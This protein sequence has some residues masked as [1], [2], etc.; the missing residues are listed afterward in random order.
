M[1][2]VILNTDGNGLWS[3]VRRAV[4]VVNI[5]LGTGRVRRWEAVDCIFGELRVYFDC[6]TWNTDRD[7]LIYTDERFLRELQAFLKV[8]GLPG[9]DVYYSEQGMQGDDYVSLDAGTEFY[10]AWMKKFGI[11][12]EALVEAW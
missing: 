2:K 12:R 9:Q 4:R 6:R 5:E 8:H 7:G 10:K 3:D 11:E 1:A